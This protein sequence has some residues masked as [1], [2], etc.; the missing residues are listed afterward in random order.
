MTAWKTI[1]TMAILAVTP[2]TTS[3][4]FAATDAARVGTAAPDFTA[5]DIKGQ[6]RRLSEFKGKTV[7]LE[8]H[9]QGCPYV[10]KHYDTGNMQSLQKEVT[11]QGA[12]WLTVISSAPG[13]QGHVT[14]EE[15]AAYLKEKQAAPTTVL[16]DAD[17]KVGRLYGA[18]TTPHM[19]IVDPAGVLV[20]AG[21]IDDKP[22]TDTADV[23]GAKNFVRAAYQEVKAGKPVSVATTA[24]YG[25]SVK[26]GD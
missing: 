4:S 3:P 7:V 8:W 16:L 18:K 23:A 15:E 5:T 24:A 13:K 25:C 12:V 2:I 6:P 11:G 19:F 22:T 21:A 9:N 1:L 26:Y 10:K 20:Y 17:G 14:S